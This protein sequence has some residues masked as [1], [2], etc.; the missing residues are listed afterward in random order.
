MIRRKPTS[1]QIK[2]VI[3]TYHKFPDKGITLEML[4]SARYATGLG[5][6]ECKMILQDYIT[7]TYG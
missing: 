3:E 5:L 4:K 1:D 7:R 2:Q 6:F